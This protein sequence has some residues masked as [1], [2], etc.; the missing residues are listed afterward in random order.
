MS[1][2]VMSAIGWFNRAASEVGS[3][4]ADAQL[5]TL[6]RQIPQSQILGQFQ[7][8]NF[9]DGVRMGSFDFLN[10]TTGRIGPSKITAS[11][12]QLAALLGRLVQFEKFA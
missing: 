10:G 4:L 2:S 11:D 3:A 9:L 6:N 1:T 5:T 7:S 12:R 8:R